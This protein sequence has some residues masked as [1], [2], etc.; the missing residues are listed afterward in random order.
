MGV[1]KFPKL[2]LSWLW[3]P[4]I[5]CSNLQLKWGL[6]QSCITY[7]DLFNNMLHDTYTHRN[8]GN[9]WLLMVG[10]QTANLT[11]DP[12]F[13]HNLCLKCPNE[14]WDPNLDIYILKSFQ[15]YKKFLNLMGFNPCNRSLKIW[16]SQSGSSLGV[17]GFIPS[18]SPTLPGTWNVTINLPTWLAPLQALALVSNP[19]LK[20]Q[21]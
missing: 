11:P 4:I 3:R 5:L 13:G 20:L 1:S 18:H 2:G 14:S 17:W 9:F 6:K 19:R 12:S 21:H 10:S 7:Q 15:R 16:E 8:W